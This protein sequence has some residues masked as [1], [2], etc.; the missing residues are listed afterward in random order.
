LRKVGSKERE[1][2]KREKIVV[3]EAYHLVEAFKE[4]VFLKGKVGM[5]WVFMLQKRVI[6]RLHRALFF[7]DT[8][9][10]CCQS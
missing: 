2:E 9:W 1:S 3:E 7:F 10:G 6:M 5:V 4:G 8:F